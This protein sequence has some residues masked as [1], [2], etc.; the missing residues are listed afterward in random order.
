VPFV[1]VWD[2]HDFGGNNSNRKASS[3]MR[4]GSLTMSV[5]HYPLLWLLTRRRYLPILSVGR[6]K[7][8]LTELRSRRDDVRKKDD[9]KIRAGSKQRVVQKELLEANGGIR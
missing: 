7:F 5:P 9:A 2:D 8:I 6:V 1:Y 4:R 3:T